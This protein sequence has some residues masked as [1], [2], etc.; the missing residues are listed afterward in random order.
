VFEQE[1]KLTAIDQAALQSIVESSDII[2]YLC[3]PVT[4]PRRFLARY[5]DTDERHFMALECSLRSRMEGDI[6]RAAFKEKGKICDGLS[7]RKEYE[8]D[9]DGWLGEIADLPG[10]ALKDS[11]TA[12]AGSSGLLETLVIVDMQRTIYDL[13]IGGTRVECV[14]DVGVIEGN[15]KKLDLYELELELKSGELEKISELGAVL[16]KKYDVKP[17]QLTKHQLG[18][19]LWDN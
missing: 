3:K 9:I 14:S 6:F 8:C 1:L 18:L 19:A 13:D 17:S 4:A 15:G 7:I 12:I 11:V 10:G 5:H 16:N 2:K